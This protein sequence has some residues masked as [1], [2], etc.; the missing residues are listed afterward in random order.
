MGLV[1][2][3]LVLGSAVETHT[4]EAICRVRAVN[5]RFLHA[6]ISSRGEMFIRYVTENIFSSWESGYIRARRG[7]KVLI[8]EINKK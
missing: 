8:Y 1:K 7:R 5:A 3:V 6:E 4:V 2:T